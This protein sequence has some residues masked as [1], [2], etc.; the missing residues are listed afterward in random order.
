V[1]RKGDTFRQFLH[2][3]NETKPLIDALK[4]KGKAA[5][6]TLNEILKADFAHSD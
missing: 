4:L 3:S 1:R 2:F 6:P 5:I